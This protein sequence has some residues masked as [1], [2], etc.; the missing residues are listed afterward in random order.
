LKSGDE[1]CTVDAGV[2]ERAG[3]GAEVG[4]KHADEG[5]SDGE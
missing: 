5:V 1:R 4:A 3:H 2:G